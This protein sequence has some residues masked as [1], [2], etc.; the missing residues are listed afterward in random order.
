MVFF[1]GPLLEKMPLISLLFD[2][3]GILHFHRS[4]IK[5]IVWFIW[6]YLLNK[7]VILVGFSM[8]SLIMFNVALL[9]TYY[10]PQKIEAVLIVF[11]I[12]LSC[13]TKSLNL[14]MA[15]NLSIIVKQDK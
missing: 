11:V 7:H 10:Q 9:G 3:R 8:F 5:R 6:F 13:G 14:F 15:V 12:T 4:V 2:G 1:S